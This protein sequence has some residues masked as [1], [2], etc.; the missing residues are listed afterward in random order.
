MA[1]S[2]GDKINSA[3]KEGKPI[4]RNKASSLAAAAAAAEA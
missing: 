2:L 3:Q 4:E 1:L